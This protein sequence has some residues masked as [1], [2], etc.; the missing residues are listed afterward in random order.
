MQEKENLEEAIETQEQAIKPKKRTRKIKGEELVV[1]L[2]LKEEP[3][4]EPKP[5]LKVY[6]P[7]KKRFMKP[8]IL[9]NYKVHPVVFK[10]YNDEYPQGLYAYC[11]LA[12]YNRDK[13]NPKKAK[14]VSGI[15]KTQFKNLLKDKYQ[16]DK[17]LGWDASRV[18]EYLYNLA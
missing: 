16:M 12:T 3:K 4:E 11:F 2:D 8:I 13:L 5:E 17:I 10:F 7:E 15:T 9:R 18:N 6:P 14:T 1:N